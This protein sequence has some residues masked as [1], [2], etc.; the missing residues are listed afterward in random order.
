VSPARHP[1]AD[2]PTP[3]L[4]AA[5][6][7]G[8]PKAQGELLR[9]H[10]RLVEWAL[11]RLVGTT[12]EL[13][14]LVQEVFVEAIRG[15]PRFRGDA[16]FETWLRG[17][18]VHVACHWLRAPRRRTVLVALGTADPSTPGEVAEDVSARLAFRRLHEL[19]DRVSPAKRVAFLLHVAMGHSTREVA[20]LTHSTHAAAKSRIWF[21][22][23]EITAL[24]RED[25][26]LAA[27]LKEVR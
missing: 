13:E 19:L 23:R 5:A 16:R 20:A 17:V 4:V 21:A 1:S 18:A 2:D 3:V 27:W 11:R 25:P 22:R 15:L 12:P 9:R 10:A 14:D 26:L 6:R 7:S 8:D 24:A